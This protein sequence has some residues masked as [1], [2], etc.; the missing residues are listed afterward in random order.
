[1]WLG[2]PQDDRFDFFL[3]GA[4]LRFWLF[5]YVCPGQLLKFADF[6]LPKMRKLFS[7]V[8][9]FRSEVVVFS[10]IFSQIIELP[11]LVVGG[12][13]LPVVL[14]DSPIVFVQP[15]QTV[16]F[17]RDVLGECGC[18]VVTWGRRQC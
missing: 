17:N 13:E 6:L 7:F 12:D 4:I 2:L 8:R 10:P 9:I 16:A 11:L 14:T 18:E 5:G 3:R 1:M 15:P